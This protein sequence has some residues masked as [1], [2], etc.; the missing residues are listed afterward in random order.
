MP[1]NL[2]YPVLSRDGRRVSYLIHDLIS[3]V[4]VSFLSGGAVQLVASVPSREYFLALLEDLTGVLADFGIEAGG[5]SNHYSLSFD[6]DQQLIDLIAKAARS[7]GA[8]A[9]VQDLLGAVLGV[10][11]V[12]PPV[13]RYPQTRIFFSDGAVAAVTGTTYTPG[14]FRFNVYV[15]DSNFG[16]AEAIACILGGGSR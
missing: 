10:A 4:S 13:K 7:R 12:K 3:P 9:K 15:T 11:D 8:V 14:S 2:P 6:G 1:L 16:S 5:W